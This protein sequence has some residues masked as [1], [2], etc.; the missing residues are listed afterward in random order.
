M[1]SRETSN[2]TTNAWSRRI[3]C[4]H[5][6]HTM[7]L[8][9]RRYTTYR[10]CRSTFF[11]MLY[12]YTVPHEDMCSYRFARAS[13][14]PAE[15]GDFFDVPCT[16]SKNNDKREKISYKPR[17]GVNQRPALCGD[18]SVLASNARWFRT[19]LSRTE[20]PSGPRK[21][22]VATSYPYCA[23]TVEARCPITRVHVTHHFIPRR[24]LHEYASTSLT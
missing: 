1:I 14:A 10:T 16:T 23:N 19:S 18:W 20:R 7:L 3:V 5:S 13:A 12:T 21:I 24:Q 22:P 4:A 11:S 2:S 6:P 8:H 15:Q 17:S 9:Q